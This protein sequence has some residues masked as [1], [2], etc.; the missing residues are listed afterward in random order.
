MFQKGA[1]FF[2]RNRT[3]ITFT[4][5]GAASLVA[6][7]VDRT[8]DEI[9]RALAYCDAKYQPPFFYAG[10]INNPKFDKRYKGGEDALVVS[11]N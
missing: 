11:S 4:S 8:I 9:A 3:A 2:K 5:I 6:W 10:V 1:A 7:K